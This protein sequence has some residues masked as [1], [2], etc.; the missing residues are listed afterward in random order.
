MLSLNFTFRNCDLPC[1]R[2][3]IKLGKLFLFTFHTNMYY[4]L[5]QCSQLWLLMLPAGT[6]SLII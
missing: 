2:W 1:I 6:H 3:G 4:V 5:Q